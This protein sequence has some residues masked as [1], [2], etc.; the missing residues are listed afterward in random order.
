MTSDDYVDKKVKAKVKWNQ[1][2]L[3][4]MESLLGSNCRIPLLHMSKRKVYIEITNERINEFSF[5]YM[6]NP[7]LYRHKVFTEQLKICLSS[8]FGAD[9]IKRIN[10]ILKIP[11]TRVIAL[12]M[13]YELGSYST[14]KVF[15]VLSCV[16]YT[17]IDK[18]VCIDYLFT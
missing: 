17:M 14:I 2:N 8:T 3:I 9:T 12:I 5:A 13:I 7:H 4:S 10:L 1:I 11:N 6:C 15:K 16:V 18:Y